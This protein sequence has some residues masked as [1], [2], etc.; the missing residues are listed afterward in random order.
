MTMAY[1]ITTTRYDTERTR[2]DEFPNIDEAKCHFS[3]LAN[4]L[5]SEAHCNRIL[6]DAHGTPGARLLWH[7]PPG[8]FT[9]YFNLCKFAVENAETGKLVAE[10]EVTLPPPPMP[11]RCAMNTVEDYS[12]LSAMPWTTVPI[13]RD[14]CD[15][16]PRAIK[17]FRVNALVPKFRAGC[18]RGDMLVIDEKCYNGFTVRC[19]IPLVAIISVMTLHEKKVQI[20]VRSGEPRNFVFTDDEC[21]FVFQH[22]VE[23]QLYWGTRV[24]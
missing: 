11:V 8:D 21:A 24:N 5:V 16:S 15:V 3:Y 14:P 22:E 9:K 20:C 10:V 12:E 19:M 23:M 4:K 2:T 6:I 7:G 1:K 18:L 13:V 17:E